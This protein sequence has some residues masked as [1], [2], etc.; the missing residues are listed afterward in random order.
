MLRF[1]PLQENWV[2][3]NQ[4]LAVLG[5]LL[6]AVGL[7]KRKVIW[8][9]YISTKFQGVPEG[10]NTRMLVLDSFCFASDY[11]QHIVSLQCK[12]RV[13]LGIKKILVMYEAHIAFSANYTLESYLRTQEQNAF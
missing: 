12:S 8:L 11:S 7:H 9:I 3:L 10:L 2:K 4:K 5:H 13:R 6:V 1:R